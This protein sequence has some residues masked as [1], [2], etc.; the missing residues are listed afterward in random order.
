MALK[1]HP[2]IVKERLTTGGAGG[3]AAAGRWLSFACGDRARR[4]DRECRKE[5]F[6]VKA[7]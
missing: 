3:E 1:F 2:V 4:P 5:F 6:F 7:R